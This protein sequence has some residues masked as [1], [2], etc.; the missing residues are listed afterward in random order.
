MTDNHET[1][2]LHIGKEGIDLSSIQKS[3]TD[4]LSLEA[5]EV[6]DGDIDMDELLNAHSAAQD[7]EAW[8]P[9][10]SPE[11]VIEKRRTIMKIKRYYDRFAKH[12]PAMGDLEAKPL[13]EL[14]TFL[15]E[16]KF[17]VANKNTGAAVEKSFTGMC[18]M[19][20]QLGP[21]LKPEATGLR[22]CHREP[23]TYKG[24]VV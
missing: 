24:L 8:K 1:I 7:M 15:E 2:Q 23:R 21:T 12:L 17:M 10:L 11:E 6:E 22:C 20:E 9:S 4:G 3:S 16:V 5:E 14:T 19:I 13:D 18:Y